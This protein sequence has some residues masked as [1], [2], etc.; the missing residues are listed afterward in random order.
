MAA[1]RLGTPGF[2]RVRALA[3]LFPLVFPQQAAGSAGPN[4]LKLL[5]SLEQSAI[6][7]PF[8]ARAT[9]HLHNA[10]QGPLWLYR[11]ARGQGASRVPVSEENRARETTGGSKL[12]I[13]LQPAAT[14]NPQSIATPAKGRVLDSVGL[15]RPKLL[16]VG[17]GD[18]YEEK[19][20]LQLA[21]ALDG[22]AKPIWGH[23][24]LS[25]TYRAS[26]S[27]AE[28]IR[29]NLGAEVW[30]GEVASNTIDVELLPPPAT[31]QGSISGT[32]VA[33][34]SRPVLEALVSLSDAQERLVDQVLTDPEGRF[35]FTHLPPGLYWATARHEN[36]AEDTAVFRHVEI[37]SAE[38]Q[39]ALQLMFLAEDI[40]EPQKLLH[41]P[42]LFRVTD[43]A[44]RPLGRVSL[45]VTWS[46]GPI[47]DNVKG[48][49]GD[50][51]ATVLDLIPGRNFL[52]LKGRGCPKQEERA[53]VAAGGGI[54]GFK[55]ILECEKR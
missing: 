13:D 24:R 44:G 48:E 22:A 2:H 40:Y 43:S 47:V 45:E 39:G 49:T 54:D 55:F 17:P 23:Y 37:T 42:V 1:G 25:V 52:T 30:D 19:T 27:N 3:L 18:D 29:R 12:S 10:G 50:D 35:S 8:P 31:S 26:F 36:S 28:E 4:P 20:T 38:P 16:R 33:P 46:N 32:V 6:T 7:S 5:I 21:P 41:K 9:L 34:D 14:P 53:D 11:R 15:P 51:G